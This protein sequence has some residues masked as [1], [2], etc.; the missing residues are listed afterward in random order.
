M[1]SASWVVACI[2]AAGAWGCS[3]PGTSGTPLPVNNPKFG[4]KDPKTGEIPSG[5]SSINLVLKPTF[6]DQTTL[7][8]TKQYI[9]VLRA[10][11]DGP[12]DKLWELMPS[13][14][15][16]GGASVDA[17]TNSG[18]G[19]SP[20]T[21]GE[22][23]IY[24]YAYDNVFDLLCQSDPWCEYSTAGKQCVAVPS[25]V[26]LCANEAAPKPLVGWCGSATIAN[27]TV[28]VKLPTSSTPPT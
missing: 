24:L 2:F 19:I 17:K 16:E 4:I 6:P 9:V 18:S 15:R 23:A 20:I 27:N 25:G 10:K 5:F 12:C 28:E 1:R 21:S 22:V 14:V 13:G 8:S 7:D 11:A 3:D 26:Q